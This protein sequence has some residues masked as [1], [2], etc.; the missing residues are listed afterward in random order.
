MYRY[1]FGGAICVWIGVV[2]VTAGVDLVVVWTL[3]VIWVAVIIVVLVVVE[4][5]GW[6]GWLLEVDLVVVDFRSWWS[7]CYIGGG[8]D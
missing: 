1:N 6:F 3:G 8:G 7:H 4:T 2:W 5:G